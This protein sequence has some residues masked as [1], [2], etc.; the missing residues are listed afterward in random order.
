MNKTT[1]FA[2]RF[3]LF[4]RRKQVVFLS[5]SIWRALVFRR[6]N[7]A[8]SYKLLHQ[9]PCQCLGVGMGCSCSAF[10]P[11]VEEVQPVCDECRVHQFRIGVQWQYGSC[12][13]WRAAHFDEVQVRE[14]RG[15]VAE[16]PVVH[17]VPF[18]RQAF[19]DVSAKLYESL[20]PLFLFHVLVGH[21]LYPRGEVDGYLVAEFVFVI[22]A[23][24]SALLRYAVHAVA[25]ILAGDGNLRGEVDGHSSLMAWCVVREI[26][27]VVHFPV[28][29]QYP[30]VGGDVVMA[31]GRLHYAKAVGGIERK[32]P[33]LSG[34]PWHAPAWRYAGC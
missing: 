21:F 10:S 6:V 29:R 22:V 25:I 18:V 9:G 19:G 15:Q 5:W 13:L 24:A 4:C 27:Q 30:Q 26:F 11:E 33:L 23:V 14:F 3:N 32:F 17:L 2:W 7:I 16:V 1:Y 31:L 8:S 20:L 34:I 28:L 12:L